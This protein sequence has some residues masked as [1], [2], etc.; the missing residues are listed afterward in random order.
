MVDFNEFL[1]IVITHQGD[2]TDIIDEICTAFKLIAAGS[3]NNN[4]VKQKNNYNIIMKFVYVRI[5][6]MPI[7]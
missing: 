2:A 3:H 7:Y 1:N 6:C 4:N 5:D